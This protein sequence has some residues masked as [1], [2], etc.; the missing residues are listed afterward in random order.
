MLLVAAARVYGKLSVA[1]V[2]VA[3]A[4]TRAA[5]RPV[6]HHCVHAAVAPSSSRRIGLEAVGVC[7]REVGHEAWLRSERA[8]VAIPP[9]VGAEVGLRRQCRGKTESAVFL[10]GNP[11]E[12]FNGFGRERGGKSEH[13]APQRDAAIAAGAELGIG[14]C[15]MARVGRVVGRDAVRAS[16]DERLH[17]IVPSRCRFRTFDSR[18]QHVAQIVVGE[19]LDLRVAE[20][21]S[22]HAAFGKRLTS[23]G[24]VGHRQLV[25]YAV[26]HQS[27]NLVDTQPRR[28][29]G[30]AF[31]HRQTPVLIGQESVAAVKTFERLAVY[32]NNFHSRCGRV[33]QVGAV[34]LTHQ[35]EAVFF[36][37]FHPVM[38]PK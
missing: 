36:Y 32:F 20:V 26:E 22:L 29:V 25:L 16:F 17:L 14:K 1:I 18:H 2:G 38:D 21:V 34:G 13:I 33:A 5:A 31:L 7:A 12:L 28:K 30:C 3:A 19:K 15:R 37:C 6:L 23:V 35:V 4:F 27:G 11:A 9:R 10:A 8:A 24:V